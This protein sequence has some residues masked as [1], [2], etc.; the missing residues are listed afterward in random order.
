MQSLFPTHQHWR[1][2]AGWAPVDGGREL[3][4]HPAALSDPSWSR[5]QQMWKADVQGEEI[6]FAGDEERKHGAACGNS[7]CPTKASCMLLIK[8]LCSRGRHTKPASSLP[9][10]LLI[11]LSTAGSSRAF[12]IPGDISR[13]QAEDFQQQD[14]HSSCLNRWLTIRAKGKSLLTESLAWGRSPKYFPAPVL[15]LW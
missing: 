13:D 7:T 14:V 5:R 6:G 4:S 9:H 2:L 11:C 8:R 3:G 10:P 1:I 15:T 12:R